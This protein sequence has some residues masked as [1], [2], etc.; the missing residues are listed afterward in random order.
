[1][2]EGCVV[3]SFDR[4]L[5]TE[6]AQNRNNHAFRLQR[7]TSFVSCSNIIMSTTHFVIDHSKYIAVVLG[8]TISYTCVN[9]A[10]HVF[11]LPLYLFLE[12][13]TE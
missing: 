2:G 4:V 12:A 3:A 10:L 13:I 8:D 7:A 11:L 5:C 1:M 6:L 9:C